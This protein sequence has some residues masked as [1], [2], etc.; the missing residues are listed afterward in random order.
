MLRAVTKHIP[1]FSLFQVLVCPNLKEHLN[2]LRLSPLRRNH[3]ASPPGGKG[4]TKQRPKMMNNWHRHVVCIRTK[5]EH[6][7]VNML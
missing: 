5:Y 4:K 2:S 3:A 1:T 6:D 7:A